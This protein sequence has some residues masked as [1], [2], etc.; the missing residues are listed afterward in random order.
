MLLQSAVKT[1]NA[2]WAAVQIAAVSVC[3]V[4]ALAGCSPQSGASAGPAPGTSAA[5]G[6]AAELAKLRDHVAALEQEIKNLRAENE[7]LKLTPGALLAAVEQAVAGKDLPAAQNAQQRLAAK[8]PAS[9]ETPRGDRL[10]AG[11]QARHLAEAREAERVAA[12]GLRAL[13]VA[14]TFQA[15]SVK[16]VLESAGAGRNWVFDAYAGN[17]RYKEAERG[18]KWV[19]ARVNISSRD[20]DPSLPGVAVYVESGK[21]LRRVGEM[22]YR[23]A[24]W[25]DYG[26]YLGNHADYRNDFAHTA[27]IPFSLGSSVNDNERSPLYVVA[28]TEGCHARDYDRFSNPPVSYMPRNCSSL[29]S[30][31]GAEDFK[32]GSLAVLRR[33]EGRTPLKP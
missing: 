9:S 13:K 29:K 2:S 33:I 11:E 3:A 17:Y 7:E 27:T 19:T 15:G 25:D 5:A 31:L 1:R 18:Q 32:D 30:E 28:T 10:L 20:K 8:Y 16:V 14:N 21:T 24:R 12:L 22:W 6:T 23:F 26:S 4:A